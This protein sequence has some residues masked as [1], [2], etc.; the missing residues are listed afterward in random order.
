ME[1]WQYVTDNKRLDGHL[2]DVSITKPFLGADG[3]P[4]QGSGSIEDLHNKFHGLIGKAGV[5]G[6]P[7]VAAY[8]PVFFIHHWWVIYEL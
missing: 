2:F 6:N 3:R 7:S 8:D 4:A 5:M 1:A